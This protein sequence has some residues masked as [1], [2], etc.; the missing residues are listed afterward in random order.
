MTNLRKPTVLAFLLAIVATQTI[1]SNGFL[2]P[3]SSSNIGTRGRTSPTSRNTVPGAPAAIRGGG[4]QP[5]K[6]PPHEEEEEKKDHGGVVAGLFG[7]LRIPASLIAGASLGSAFA[8]PFLASDTGRIDFAKRMYIF[9]MITTLGSMLMVVILSTIV[10]NDVCLRPSRRTKS[11]RDYVDEYYALEWMMVRSSFF[12][13]ALAFIV[14]S[15]FRAWIS[16]ECPVLGKAVVGIL[17]S[18][19]V[20]S[21]SYMA[22]Q[23]RVQYDRPLRQSFLLYVKAVLRRTKTNPLFGIGVALW[24]ISN[25]YL[26]VKLPHMYSF[27]VNKYS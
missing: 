3:P 19:S 27:L 15:A 22:D 8:L 4:Q 18:I 20:V 14:G 1:V 2:F 24:V 13:G 26:L 21:L 6:P 12:Y 17:S 11:V 5:Q 9:S 23:V 25:S 16:I 10:M 7:N